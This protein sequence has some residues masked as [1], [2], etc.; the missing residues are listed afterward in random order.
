MR[1]V[2]IVAAEKAEFEGILRRRPKPEPLSWP[3]DYSAAVEWNGSRRLL[4]ANGAGPGLAGAAA[5][6]ARERESIDALVS[7]GFC[8]GLNP[9]LRPGDVVVARTIEALER[10]GSY[11][12]G[13]PATGRRFHAGVVMSVDRIVATREEKSELRRRGGDAVEMEAAGLA[14]R[15]ASWRL[16]IYCIRAVTDTA[17]ESFH[18]D[19]NS[20][21]D[22]TGRISRWKVAGGALR[23]PVQGV[24]ELLRLRRRSLEAAEQLGDF[25]ADCTF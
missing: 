3:L 17:E 25:I 8:G 20:A 4:A 21:R 16:P 12:A 23:R 11:E 10:S 18:L 7:F 22:E 14:G 13:T 9:D 19:L 1:T 5:D 6:A 2:L 24:P 15:A